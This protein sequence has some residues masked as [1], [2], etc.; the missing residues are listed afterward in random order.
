[1]HWSKERQGS[2]ATMPFLGLFWSAVKIDTVFFGLIMMT[3]IYQFCNTPFP[4]F[5]PSALYV[6]GSD[7]DIICIYV[8]DDLY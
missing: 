3:N 2:N 6:F 8:T 5:Y 7:S 1:M 4:L